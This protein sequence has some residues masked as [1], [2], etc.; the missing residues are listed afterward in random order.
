MRLESQGDMVKVVSVGVSAHGSTPEQGQNAIS[1]MMLFLNT[2]PLG[3]NDQAAYIS[4]YVRLI[5]ME[6][7]GQ[8][9]GVEFSDELSGLL[10]FNVGIINMDQDSGEVVVN[11]R[12]PV[13]YTGQQVVDGVKG[14]LVGTGITLEGLSDSKPH[15]VPEDHFLIK[16]LSKVYE[17][18]TGEPTR[19]IAI[20]GGTYARTMPNSV[21]F[22]PG[23]PGRPD[24]AH[25]ENENIPIEDLILNTKINARAIYELIKSE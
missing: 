10:I 21:A 5:G 2:L 16:A 17:E 4:D 11:I 3:A 15:H 9:I 20:G 14:A 1:Q 18:M 22:G 19:L 7:N 23:I 25:K 6:Y 24:V 13:A 12:Y 8:S